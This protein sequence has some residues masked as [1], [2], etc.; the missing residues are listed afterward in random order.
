MLKERLKDWAD[1][2]GYKVAT[3]GMEVFG[4]VRRKLMERKAAGAFDPAF[5]EGS[6]AGFR[7]L[8]GVA[9]PGPVAVVMV[10]VPS[11]IHTVPLSIG[12]RAVEAL[13]PPTYVRYRSTFTDVLADLKDRVL[14]PDAAAE[15]PKVPL[16]S[17]AAHMGLVVYGRNNITYVPGLGSGHQLCGFVIGGTD[18]SLDESGTG[19]A[20]ETVMDRCANCR[21]CL[22]VCPTG[23]IR[24]D[25]FL[26]SAERCFTYL[27]ESRRPMP[28]WA[29]PPRTLC[30]IG[31]M[32]CQEVC[33]ENRGRLRKAPSGVELT[34]EETAAV[35]EAGRKPA[36]GEAGA[37]PP[38]SECQSPAL[39]S[40]LSKFERLGLT[41]DLEVMGRNLDVFI[42]RRRS[43]RRP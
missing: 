28:D 36:A 37:K 9:L 21:A 38:A 31:C 8:D 14:P 18:G 41:D 5:F 7:F 6:L 4:V 27:S 12:G 34:E 25:R 19:P 40:A 26:I 22:E 30:L 15:V 20:A 1:G 24:E 39:A 11:P 10:A 3:A 2:R 29:R 42:R 32:A 33:P 16:K 23:A 35:L 17:L 13:I 43:S